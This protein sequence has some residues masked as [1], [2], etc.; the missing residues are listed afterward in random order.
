MKS[1]ILSAALAA[2]LAAFFCGCTKQL[3]NDTTETSTDTLRPG[4]PPPSVGAEPG[5]PATGAATKIGDPNA[6]KESNGGT[7]TEA[8][9]TNTTPHPAQ[10]N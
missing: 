9:V 3:S 4:T 10:T 7:G 1:R 5:G 2:T 8:N 6:P